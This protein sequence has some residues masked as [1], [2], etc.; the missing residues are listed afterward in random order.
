MS[1]TTPNEPSAPQTPSSA[2]VAAPA[3][4]E[5]PITATTRRPY[6]APRIVSSRIFHKVMLASPQP[7]FPG[8]STY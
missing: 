4:A 5:A 6:Q 1:K 8:C 3:T 7:G 2:E